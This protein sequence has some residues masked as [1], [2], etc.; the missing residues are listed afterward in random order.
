MLEEM[1]P[2]WFAQTMKLSLNDSD[3]YRAGVRSARAV[4][5]EMC[6]PIFAS[7]I[8]PGLTLSSP[9][10]NSDRKALPRL[11][12]RTPLVGSVNPFSPGLLVEARWRCGATLTAASPPWSRHRQQVAFAP[13]WKTAC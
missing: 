11:L 5:E 13:R 1:A 7:R 9:R 8:L 2:R 6:T 3:D 4:P 12:P 10:T